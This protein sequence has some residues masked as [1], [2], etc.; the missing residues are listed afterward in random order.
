MTKAEKQA[1]I[2]TLQIT[3]EKTDEWF[4]TKE[5]SEAFIVGFLQGTIKQV[6]RELK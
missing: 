4:K 1:L 5:F 6:I 2:E 3:I